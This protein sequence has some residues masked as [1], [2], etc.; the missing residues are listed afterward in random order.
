MSMFKNKSILF[1]NH[2]LSLSRYIIDIPILAIC[3]TC[4]SNNKIIK[5]INI[6]S[7]I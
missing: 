2:R 7:L 1:C 6:K 3:Y 4:Q 5:T